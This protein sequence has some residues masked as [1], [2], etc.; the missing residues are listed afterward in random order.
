MSKDEAVSIIIRLL[1]TIYANDIYMCAC[2][3][4]ADCSY[5]ETGDTSLL[6][7]Y[8]SSTIAEIKELQT[9]LEEGRL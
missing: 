5:R 2:I 1:T 8:L 7:K 9:I 3:Y 6:L 4:D